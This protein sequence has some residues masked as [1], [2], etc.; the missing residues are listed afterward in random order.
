MNKEE[1]D[2]LLKS[3]FP[4]GEERWVKIKYHNQEK[5]IKSFRLS[6]PNKQ[7]LDKFINEYGYEVTALGIR[8]ESESQL[9]RIIEIREE[10]LN[11]AS[12]ELNSSITSEKIHEVFN[13]FISKII[14]QTTIY[15]L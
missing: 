7:E 3:I 12:F 5:C 8:P 10:L 14:N 13:N 9:E 15:P 11:V 6:P 2:N 4:I 1:I